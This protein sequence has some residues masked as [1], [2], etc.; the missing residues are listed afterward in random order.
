[1]SV[2]LFHRWLRV[3]VLLA[4]AT[5]LLPAVSRPLAVPAASTV[6]PGGDAGVIVQ[7][8]SASAAAIAVEQAGG[9]VQRQLTIIDAV[10]ALVPAEGLAR[11]RANPR[12]RVHTNARVRAA[13]EAPFWPA[14]GRETETEGY[15]LYP[16]AATGAAALHKRFLPTNAG[17]CTN[18]HVIPNPNTEVLSLEG[19][20]VTVAVIDSGMIR[21]RNRQGANSGWDNYDP[22]TGT[23]YVEGDRVADQARCIVYRDFL[24]RDPAN[25]NH[26]TRP[27][28]PGRNSTDQNGHGTHVV[29][30]IGD[31]RL[32]SL[33]PRVRGPVGVAPKVNLVVA[34]ALDKDGAGRYDD[35]IAAIQWVLENRE[36]YAIRV[37]NLSIYAEV[38]GPY[39]SDPLNQAVMQ[40][41]R[42]GIVVVVAAG[43]SGPAAGTITAPGNVPYVITVGALRSGRYNVSGEDELADYSSRGPTESAFVKPDVLVPASRTIAPVPDA[44]TVALAIPE[45]RLYDKE[46]VDFAVGRSDRKHTYYQLS[47][48]SMASAQVSGLVA[49]MLQAN[50]GLT[51]DQVKYR[52]LATARPAI[53]TATGQPM[54]S[55]WEQGAGLIDAQQAV[56]CDASPA[57]N[58]ALSSANAGMN[59]TADLTSDTHYW[60]NTEWF[61][62][63][64]EFRLID[65]DTLQP[66]EIWAG[67]TR[68]W[69]G[70]TRVWA[71]KTRVWAGKTRVWAGKTRVW[72]GAWAP[73]WVNETSL[74]AGKTRVW[75]G[76]APITDVGAASSGSEMLFT[77]QQDQPIYTVVMPLALR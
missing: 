4:C 15:T 61:D 53:E 10:S 76:S 11:L 12:L 45:A 68:V 6:A 71:G 66:V 38:A 65:P 29:S 64:G 18:Q 67:K 31:N 69:A 25:D 43:N 73:T 46:D 59:I 3:V 70:K 9:V 77:D 37:L 30:T 34:R 27:N 8:A 32:G 35:M 5:A 20:G 24:P 22:A 54:Y 60:G 50:P 62:P 39:W 56:L 21:M 16:S 42:A 47:G 33:A 51:N 14:A 36:R 49:L 1:M 28:D 7:A 74:W 75:A 48:T 23:L 63:P 40:A 2:V 13:Q 44:S 72:A 58:C 52:L 26:G 55:I 19:W 41:W 17:T 57:E